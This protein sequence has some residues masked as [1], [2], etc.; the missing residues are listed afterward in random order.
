[1][2]PVSLSR[3][4]TP[5][6]AYATIRCADSEAEIPHLDDFE[7]VPIDSKPPFCPGTLALPVDQ[8]SVFYEK[9]GELMHGMSSVR[10]LFI[11]R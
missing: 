1:M 4:A 11:P 7:R 3:F 6:P 9:D 10:P 5:K 8:L 2:T